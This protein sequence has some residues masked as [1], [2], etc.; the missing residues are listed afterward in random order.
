MS[1]LRFTPLAAVISVAL[2]APVWANDDAA[3]GVDNT[4]ELPRVKVTALSSAI[5]I[6]VP[7]TVSVIDRQ[8]MDRRLVLNIRDLV[9]Y[10]PGVSAIGTAGRWGLDSFSIRG[11]DG[12]RVS[13]QTDGVTAANSFGFS[14]TGMRAGRNYVDLDTIKS[15]EIVRGP[16]SALDSS[17]AL[18]GTVRYVTKDPADYLRDSRNY[19]SLKEQY[20]SA[21]RGLTTS[22]TVAGGDRANGI[23]IVATHRQSHEL[24]NQGDIRSTDYT[25]T[26]P[27]PLDARTDSVLAKYVHTATSGREDRFTADIFN[28]RVNT[29]VYS[30]LNPKAPQVQLLDDHAEDTSKRMRVSFEQRYSKIDS[31][32]ADRLDWNVYWQKTETESDTRTL[33]S[34]PLRGK[35]YDRLYLSSL[36][37]RLFGGK[38]TLRKDAAIGA[39][40]HRFAYGVEVSRTT[41]TGQLGGTGTDIATGITSSKT[42]YMPE[43]YPLSFF[44]KNNTDRYAVFVQDEIGLLDDRLKIVPGMRFDRYSFK[45]DSGDRYFA[46]SFV[47]G[48]LNQVTHNRFSPKLGIDYAATDSVNVYAN[49]AQGFRPPLYSELAVAWGTPRLYGI[50]PNPQ[51]KPETSKGLELGVRGRGDFGYYSASVYYNRYRDFIFGGYALRPEQWP[52]WARDQ[53]LLIVMQSVNFPKATVKGIEASAGLELG[54]LTESL[55]GWRL[56]GSLSTERGDKTVYGSGVST[57]LNSVDPGTAVLGIAYDTERWGAELIGKG[58]RRKNRLD[59]PELFRAPGYATLDMYAHWKPLSMLELSAG[60]SNITDRRYW[61]WG[62]LHGGVLANVGSMNGS[63]IDDAQMR[64]A[65]IDRLSM[66]GRSFNFS[67]RF[68]F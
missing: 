12:N 39:A 48:G 57:P 55:H 49:Y 30:A 64:S 45:P 50:V 38:L 2:A 37:E 43:N 42:P 47:Q 28:N 26:R 23:M 66:P 22:L 68:T 40:E 65:Q 53:N 10:E 16:A 59:A 32:L 51:L 13:I 19:V 21:D 1:I 24:A 25:R 34:V 35:V 7:G 41:P 20:G 8:Q 31:A 17:D 15:V 67:A 61:D 62:G 36:S 27:D 46:G 18:G 6:D 3:P 58:V 44:P 29:K 54:A 14:T 56:Q 33:A 63:G 52:Q 9:N 11:L 60:I 5:K 4:T